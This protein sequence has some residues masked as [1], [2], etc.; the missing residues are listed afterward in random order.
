LRS[1][2]YLQSQ[3]SETLLQFKNVAVSLYFDSDLY[4]ITVKKNAILMT[5]FNTFNFSIFEFQILRAE[6]NLKKVKRKA[7]QINNDP[8]H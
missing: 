4:C 1:A 2:W 7:F 5:F 6:T 8:L 3:Y